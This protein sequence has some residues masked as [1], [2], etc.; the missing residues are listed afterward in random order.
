MFEVNQ[1]S[2]GSSPGPL[3]V[4]GHSYGADN[5]VR[6][7]RELQKRGIEVDLLLLLD[8]TSPPPIPG[9]VRRCVHYYEPTIFGRLLPFALAGHPVRLADPQARTELVNRRISRNPII[10]AIDVVAH[11]TVD[12]DPAIHELCLGEIRRLKQGLERNVGARV[13]RARPGD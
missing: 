4:G 8:A 1:H 11:F 12:A 2:L 10:S 7:C 9:N 3:V 6:L 13:G 5:A